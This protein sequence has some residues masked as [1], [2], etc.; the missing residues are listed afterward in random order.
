MAKRDERPQ[1]E[2]QAQA[3]LAGRKTTQGEK[4]EGFHA[5]DTTGRRA[6][7]GEKGQGSNRSERD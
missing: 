7:A 1:S 2:A 4:Y 6:G 5:G 3:K